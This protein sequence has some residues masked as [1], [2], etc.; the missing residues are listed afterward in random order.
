MNAM[1]LL[2]GVPHC[3]IFTANQ[4]AIGGIIQK[5]YIRHG[6]NGYSVQKARR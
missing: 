1:R 4:F 6:K 2:K 3:L 5:K